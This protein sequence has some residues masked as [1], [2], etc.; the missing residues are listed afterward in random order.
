MCKRAHF[1]GH[2]SGL[3]LTLVV[4]L[5][6]NARAEEWSFPGARYQA[7]GG[8]GVAVVNDGH[9][10]Y[11]NPGA[12]A[13]EHSEGIELPFSLSAA[14]IGDTLADA[15]D[16][17]DFIDENAFASVLTKIGSGQALTSAELQ[18]TLEVAVGKLPG[19]G[20]TGEGLMT[21]PDL[22]LVIQKNRLVITLRG[23]GSLGIDP[24]FDLNNLALS[25]DATAALQV[26]NAVGAGNDRSLDFTNPGSQSLAD[27]IAT[28]FAD[29]DQNQAEELIFQAE[30]TGLNTSAIDVRGLITN[31]A[32]DT[33]GLTA[34]ALSANQSGAFVRGLV[35]QEV[36]L[37]YAHPFF[38]ARV[39]LGANLRLIRGISSSQF[40]RYDAIKNSEDLVHE[41]TDTM[42]TE[43]S[44]RVALDLG[45]LIRPNDR[46]RLGVTAHN[47]N[48][49]GF[50]SS[51]PSDFTLKPQVRAGI[52]LNLRPNWVVAADIDLTEN[53]SEA[54]DGFASRL[55]SVGTEYQL[56]R[57]E[58]KLALRTGAFTNLASG[59]SESVTVTAGFGFRIWHL[60][61][62][63]AVAASP[64]LMEI[65]SSGTE[66]PSRLNVSGSIRWVTRF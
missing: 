46:W 50:E 40:I 41:L 47:L 19:L 14:T 12:L 16:L 7:M 33:A 52:A 17:A 59:A 56:G 66:I 11:W 13:F 24:V 37:A 34:A 26:A 23:S 57:G 20:E 55:F 39:G 64:E 10:P 49:P 6:F 48:S 15:D 29:W 38:G 25:D 36:G 60:E 43:T 28:A 45:L 1:L 44:N 54:V 62:D 3:L 65:E 2:A 4:S 58:A 9:A 8:A 61:L 5:S 51:E 27:S 21:L 42:N 32:E 35:T 63:L 30:Q 31:I 18:D 53:E 22:G